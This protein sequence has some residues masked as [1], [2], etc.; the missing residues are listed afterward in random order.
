MEYCCTVWSPHTQ[1]CI[2]RLEMV[3]HRA[4]RYVTNSYYNITSML[5]HLEWESLEARHTKCQLTL[6]FKIISGLV[7]IPQGEYLTPASTK[8][9]TRHSH[10]FRQM[11][12]SND[13]YLNSFFPKTVRLWNSL[14]ASLTDVP[15][16]VLFKQELSTMSF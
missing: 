3:Q 7:D 2:H 4:A 6:M 16:L 13:Y 10:K 8:T 12:A 5:E 9:K 1:E 15:S 14:S 11:P